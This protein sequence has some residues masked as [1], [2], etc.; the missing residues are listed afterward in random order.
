VNAIVD[1]HYQFGWIEVWGIVMRHMQDVNVLAA[2]RE[3]N[4]DVMSPQ[5]LLFGLVELLKV[6]RQW[7]QFMDISVGA[8]Q[9]ILISPVNR[10][11]IANEIPYIRAHSKFVDLA[12]VDRDAHFSPV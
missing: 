9:Q 3:R 7:S 8:D 2:K 5:R 4:F 12:N 11:E 6:C 10:S 1:R